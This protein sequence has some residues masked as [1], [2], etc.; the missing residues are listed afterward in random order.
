MRV[1]QLIMSQSGLIWGIN[2]IVMMTEKLKEGS[3]ILCKIQ[4]LG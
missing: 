3:E 4:Q 1:V 2:M